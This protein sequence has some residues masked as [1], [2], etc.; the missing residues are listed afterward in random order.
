M[1]AWIS[2]AGYARAQARA[3]H[4]TCGPWPGPHPRPTRAQAP[5]HVLV[6]LLNHGGALAGVLE[7]GLLEEDGARD[8]LAQAGGGHQQLAVRLRGREGA[9]RRWRLRAGG[10]LGGLRQQ[11]QP[12]LVWPRIPAPAATHAGGAR[13]AV[14]RGARAGGEQGGRPP[15]GSPRCSPGRWTRGACRRWRWTR[16]WPGCPC[17]WT[18]SCSARH[19]ERGGGQGVGPKSWSRGEESHVLG[20]ERHDA[21]SAAAGVQDGPTH[22]GGHQLLGVLAVVRGRLQGKGAA[23]VGMVTHWRQG[24]RAA[25]GAPA[26]AAAAVGAQPAAWAPQLRPAARSGGRGGRGPAIVERGAQG[27]ASPRLHRPPAAAALLAAWRG[28]ASSPDDAAGRTGAWQRPCWS[29]P[30]ATPPVPPQGGPPAGTLAHSR[31]LGPS[32]LH[33]GAAAGG[34]GHA[35][36]SGGSLEGHG[37][38]HLCC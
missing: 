30:L 12:Q 8:V 21:P 17:R 16:P 14:Q 33:L 18:R 35:G 31:P 38:G 7:E 5:P 24:A 28:M 32:H 37:G 22:R 23:G 27:A 13:A 10:Q 34:A 19:E 26:T 1:G 3:G 20:A 2:A 4:D 9:A 25:W 36:P 29:T 11:P 6:Q 15:G